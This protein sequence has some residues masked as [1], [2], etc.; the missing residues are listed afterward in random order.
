MH[1]IS[2][3][4]MIYGILAATAFFFG[5]LMYLT[6]WSMEPMSAIHFSHVP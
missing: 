3:R 5:G 1:L 6:L 4:K 2:E